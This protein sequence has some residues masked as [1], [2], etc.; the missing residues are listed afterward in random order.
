MSAEGHPSTFCINH[1]DWRGEQSHAHGVKV[2]LLRLVPLI[3]NQM[4]CFA[5]ARGSV[6]RTPQVSFYV[7]LKGSIQCA[8]CEI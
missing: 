3:R 8:E 6:S 1:V 7:A 5:G 2:E 4:Q